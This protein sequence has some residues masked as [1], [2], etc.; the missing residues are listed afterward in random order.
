[1]T[2]KVFEYLTVKVF[3]YFYD[4]NYLAHFQTPQISSKELRYT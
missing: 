4:C 3:E 1:M 2:V